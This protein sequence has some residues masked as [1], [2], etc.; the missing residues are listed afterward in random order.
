M[1]GIPLLAVIEGQRTWYNHTIIAFF[2]EIRVC[3]ASFS[4]IRAVPGG[5]Q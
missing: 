5:L 2:R 4:G 1:K 3:N